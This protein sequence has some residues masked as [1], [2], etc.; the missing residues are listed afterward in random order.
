ME[1]SP[2][3]VASSVR[4]TRRH[5]VINYS[6]L[7]SGKIHRGDNDD[8]MSTIDEDDQADLDQQEDEEDDEEDK[9]G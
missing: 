4:S 3:T 7:N 1:A 6:E 8:E 9:Q 2:S 5:K